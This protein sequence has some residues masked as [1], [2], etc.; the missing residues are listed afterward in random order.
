MY[1]RAYLWL[2]AYVLVCGFRLHML[3][4]HPRVLC[5]LTT[6]ASIRQSPN[7]PPVSVI[8]CSCRPSLNALYAL[9]VAGG[10]VE[11]MVLGVGV[12]CGMIGVS[13]VERDKL[14]IYSL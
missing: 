9:I 4:L 10:G 11:R 5:R 13:R 2:C 1:A 6:P 12:W 14:Y 7:T 3:A 8:N